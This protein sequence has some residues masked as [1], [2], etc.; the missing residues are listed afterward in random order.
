MIGLGS[1]KNI[2][3]LKSS[4]FVHFFVLNN[5]SSLE[6]IEAGNSSRSKRTHTRQNL[7]WIGSISQNSSVRQTQICTGDKIYVGWDQILGTSPTIRPVDWGSYSTRGFPAEKNVP[8]QPF[9]LNMRRRNHH[10]HIKGQNVS[11]STCTKWCSSCG[12]FANFL[13]TWICV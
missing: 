11:L 13:S 10:H 6:G 12:I 9:K 3:L 5:D 4:F 7:C 8:S 1:D 2:K